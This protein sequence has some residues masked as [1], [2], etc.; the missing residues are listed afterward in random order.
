[1]VFSRTGLAPDKP[2]IGLFHYFLIHPFHAGLITAI[3][4]LHGIPAFILGQRLTKAS[5]FPNPPD[6]LMQAIVDPSTAGISN[7]EVRGAS[8]RT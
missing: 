1:V 4:P 2:I 7:R 6:L 3:L 5:S 8:P